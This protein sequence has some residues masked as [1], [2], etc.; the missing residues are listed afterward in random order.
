VDPRAAQVDGRAA[1]INCVS[2]AADPIATLDDDD[3]D[4]A[5]LERSRRDESGDPGAHYD[6]PFDRPVDRRGEVSGGIP[7][8]D[9]GGV[10][11]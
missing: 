4:A 1:E 6:D 2:A 3:L 7:D 11:T 5:E 8:M 9:D 10:H